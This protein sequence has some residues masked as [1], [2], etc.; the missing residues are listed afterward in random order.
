[1]TSGPRSTTTGVNPASTSLHAAK[2]PAGPLPTR[3]R[4]AVDDRFRGDPEIH[5]WIELRNLL[6]QPLPLSG[7]YLT[8]S[9]SDP[10]KWPFPAGTSIPPDGYLVVY[11]SGM[12]VRD[13]ALDDN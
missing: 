8:D 5:D 6:S 1:M 7:L 2:S 11:A 13:P 4:E 10:L 12:D 3:R 9:R